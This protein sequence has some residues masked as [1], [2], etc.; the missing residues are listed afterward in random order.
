MVRLVPRTTGA[1]T[2]ERWPP[3][4]LGL[5][6]VRRRNGQEFAVRQFGC[7]GAPS[8]LAVRHLNP[9]GDHPLDRNER[10]PAAGDGD[11]QAAVDLLGRGLSFQRDPVRVYE[12]LAQPFEI[13]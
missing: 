2:D 1:E 10:A 6:R 12:M 7:F 13:D 4:V 11:L 8:V 9:G 3:D 5:L